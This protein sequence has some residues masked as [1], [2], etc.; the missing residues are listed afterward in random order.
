MAE[1]DKREAW[2]FYT[3]GRIEQEARISAAQAEAT[4]RANESWVES[5]Q[6]AVEAA[7]SVVYTWDAAGNRIEIAGDAFLDAERA[8]K[9][10]VKETEQAYR[11][12]GMTFASALEDWA[13]GLNKNISLA[14]ALRQD[15]GRLI[16]REGVTK[17][18]ASAVTD[19]AKGFNWRSLFNSFD[20]GTDYV[21]HDQLAMVHKGERIIPAAQNRPGAFGGGVSI[22]HIDLRGADIAAVARLERFMTRIDASIESRALGAVRSGRVRGAV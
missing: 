16:L 3:N 17:P 8:H 10:A 7:E 6:L 22:G 13:L 18:F 19:L 21:S 5:A 20:V 2:E 11:D 1:R 9:D 14:Q 4:K 15:L 12:L